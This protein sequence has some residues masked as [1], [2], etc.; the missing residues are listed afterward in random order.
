VWAPG[1]VRPALSVDSTPF[2]GAGLGLLVK[3]SPPG[4]LM[5]T[6]AP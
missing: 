1:V 5:S 2:C 4:A 6:A 3:V